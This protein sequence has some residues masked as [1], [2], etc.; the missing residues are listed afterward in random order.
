MENKKLLRIAL[1]FGATCC[2]FSCGKID[3]PKERNQLI[4]ANE[5]SEVADSIGV[6]NA[7]LLKTQKQN[8][9]YAIE[10][11]FLYVTSLKQNVMKIGLLMDSSIYQSSSLS[12]I[13]SSDRKHFIS[14]ISF[15]NRNYLSRCDVRNGLPV[16][17]YRFDIYMGESQTD[18]LRHV[19][20]D[21]TEQK[22]DLQWY[23]IL[24]KHGSLYLLAHTD[25]KVWSSD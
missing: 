17:L 23:K 21:S 15:L 7:I 2:L 12:F 3:N 11:N 22:I 16:Y 24:D 25:A 6:L 13:E 19:C 4:F 9:V 14:L 8:Y 5:I 10:G 1:M 20:L 18:L